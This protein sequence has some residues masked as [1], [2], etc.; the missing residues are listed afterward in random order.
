MTDSFRETNLKLNGR[1]K[2]DGHTVKPIEAV[3]AK[4]NGEWKLDGG[5]KNPRRR[6]LNLSHKFLRFPKGLM[7]SRNSQISEFLSL[8]SVN[9]RL[10]SS[11]PRKI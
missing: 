9:K 2:L 8:V 3:R 10:F 11:F 4:L 1:V 6:A 5:I 7:M